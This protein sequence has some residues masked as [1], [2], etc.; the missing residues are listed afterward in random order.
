MN[1]AI[2][3]EGSLVYVDTYC[4]WGTVKKVIV[5]S[6]GRSLFKVELVNDNI[7]MT[8]YR[9]EFKLEH[10]MCPL[11]RKAEE[12]SKVVEEVSIGIKFDSNKPRFSLIDV[13]FLNDIID[14]LEFGAKTYGDFNWQHVEPRRFEDALY[15]HYS[16][17]LSGEI[18]DPD[19]GKPHTAHIAANAM[20]L[21]W[22]D[23]KKK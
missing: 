16:K 14:V 23:R 22:F 3:K 5:E 4:S 1:E 7:Q 17:R 15:R 20:F 2:L 13:N 8:L 18:I 19:T 21:A 6:D 10:E 11:T 9:D 12:L